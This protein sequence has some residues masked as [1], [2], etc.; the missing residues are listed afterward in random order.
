MN[1]KV[2]TVLGV[3]TTGLV[4]SILV[5]TGP[6]QAAVAKAQGVF[7]TNTDAE[8]VPTKAIG[9]A[10]VAVTNLPAVQKVRDTAERYTAQVSV[11][12]TDDDVE[13]CTD[14]AFV[15]EGK[16]MIVD[17]V[18]AEVR[19]GETA[20]N[21]FLRGL[22]ARPYLDLTKVQDAADA[23]GSDIAGS[24]TY[25]GATQQLRFIIGPA[26]SGFDNAVGDATLIGRACLHPKG[27]SRWAVVQ[28]IGT[29][30]DL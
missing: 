5:G 8:P 18:I 21:L 4:L 26:R 23:P 6:V 9:T 25:W 10:S 20:P 12:A 14:D 11:G 13:V 28:F 1:K 15:P 27:E 17:T 24:H 7:V 30:E 16:R 3:A 22:G 2:G 19:D 29:L